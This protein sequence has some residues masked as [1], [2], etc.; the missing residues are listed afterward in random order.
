MDDGA[1]K[2]QMPQRG[3]KTFEAERARLL[4][5]KTDCMELEQKQSYCRI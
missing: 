4:A 2:R 3:N 1:I 5:A